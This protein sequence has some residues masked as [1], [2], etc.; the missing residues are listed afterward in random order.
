[1]RRVPLRL[2]DDGV[3]THILYW[4]QTTIPSCVQ[5]AISPLSHMNRHTL[6]T[7]ALPFYIARTACPPHHSEFVPDNQCVWVVTHY[8]VVLIASRSC[9]DWAAFAIP[10]RSPMQML[11]WVAWDS[12]VSK[13]A[14]PAQARAPFQKSA[15]RAGENT[16]FEAE[17]RGRVKN[18]HAAEARRT[19]AHAAQARVPL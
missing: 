19:N 1:M 4:K 11:G 8:H 15:R 12:A 10:G 14:H 6:P 18:E 17:N 13:N 9:P 5:A 3:C 7:K 16:I 2:I